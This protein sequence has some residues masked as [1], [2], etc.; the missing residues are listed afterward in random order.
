MSAPTTLTIVAGEAC[1]A[2]R[3]LQAAL[4]RVNRTR[5]MLLP[6]PPADQLDHAARD[7]VVGITLLRDSDRH[8][9]G[10]SPLDPNRQSAFITQKSEVTCPKCGYKFRTASKTD[11][12]CTACR[13]HFRVNGEICKT[14]G[15]HK[16]TLSDPSDKSA[17]SAGKGARK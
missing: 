4:E 1:A 10:Y 14:R 9:Q 3:A 16:K 5:A 7:I 6:G 12:R 8:E 17:P 15:P 11:V 2:K 13:C